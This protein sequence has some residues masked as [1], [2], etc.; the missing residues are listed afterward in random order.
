[1]TDKSN[2]SKGGVDRD[3]DYPLMQTKLFTTSNPANILTLGWLHATLT[4]FKLQAMHELQAK[5][6]VGSFQTMSCTMTAKICNEFIHRT[7]NERTA[8][9]RFLEETRAVFSKLKTISAL[10]DTKFKDFSLNSFLFPSYNYAKFMLRYAHSGCSQQRNQ[11]LIVTDF[12]KIMN[13]LIVHRQLD[14][15]LII[16]LVV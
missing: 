5:S 16:R 11:C 2:L 15:T 14:F 13:N 3:G 8:D 10:N 1:M 9:A 7:S 6:Q 12:S 4:L